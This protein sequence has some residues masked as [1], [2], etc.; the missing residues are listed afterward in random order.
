ME[1]GCIP[2]DAL[3]GEIAGTKRPKGC[4]KL[5]YKDVCKWDMKESPAHQFG[6]MG[7]LQRTSEAYGE[8]N[9]GLG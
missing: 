2:K 8:I 3:Y 1:D 6:H 5:S 9:Y 7:K 4:Q